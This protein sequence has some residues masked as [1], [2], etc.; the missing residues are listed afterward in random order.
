MRTAYHLGMTLEAQGR[1]GE[2]LAAYEEALAADPGHAGAWNNRGNV[3]RKTGRLDEAVESLSQAVLLA[4]HHPAPLTNRGNTLLML[5]HHAEAAAD[6]RRLLQ[7][8]PGDPNAPGGLLTAAQAL[9]D[10][11]TVEALTPRLAQAAANG[12]ALVPPLTMLFGFDDPALLQDAAAHFWRDQMA[13]PPVPRPP[14][15]PRQGKIRLAYCSS[16]F[17]THAT[18]WLL[19]DLIERHD[20]ARFEVIG[21]SWGADNGGP[22]RARLASAFDRFIDAQ[23]MSDAEIATL[24]RQLPVDIAIDLKGFTQGSRP[25]L[26]NLRPAP[27]QVNWL[28]F[29]GGLASG[30]H[31]YIIAD[32]VLLPHDQQ[33][34]YDEKI[35]HLPDCY[36]PNDPS[37]PLRAIGRE[38]AGLPPDAFVFAS[39][40]HY[41]KIT[42]PVF[43]LWL[44]LLAA[45]PGSVLWLLQDAASPRLRQAA[46]ARGIDPAR[47]VFAPWASL[48]DNLARL[49]CADLMLDTL[50]C[51]AHTTASDALWMGVPLV[52]CAGPS[53]AGRVAA[54]LLTAIG[55][56]ELIA[57]SLPDYEARALALAR[58]PARLA[59]LRAKL[60]ANRHTA[61][62]FDAPRFCRHI[63]RAY[64]T[65]IAIA[66][67]GEQPRPFDVGVIDPSLEP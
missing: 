13:A 17:Q 63:E 54:S 6:F 43:D 61:P 20:R 37:R 36:Q 28:G 14:P 38:S 42:R 29:P 34:F 35:V 5:N 25:G 11:E 8:A 46:T 23:G 62:L 18:A 58:D 55:V 10:W 33:A 53:F 16:D 3:L 51:G 65:M 48:E 27:L 60:A 50:P 49:A 19:A 7:L 15:A 26:F 30:V 44:R 57:A 4:P 59:A 39:F 22:M 41:R 32:P 66:E 9:C 2:A 24:L 67:A 64:E 21:V 52:T 56:P 31:D 45:V 12:S 1:L 47:L 40:N